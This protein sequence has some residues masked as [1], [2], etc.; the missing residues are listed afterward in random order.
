[1]SL[2][3]RDVCPQCGIDIWPAKECLICGSPSPSSTIES[4]RDRNSE[5]WAALKSIELTLEDLKQR[6][7]M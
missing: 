5:L 4:L 3:S 2:R 1:M 6:R 7:L